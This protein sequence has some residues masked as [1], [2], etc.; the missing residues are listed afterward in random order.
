MWFMLVTLAI[1]VAV[2]G[3]TDYIDIKNGR[4]RNEYFDDEEDK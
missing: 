2:A 1:I 4:T 3:V